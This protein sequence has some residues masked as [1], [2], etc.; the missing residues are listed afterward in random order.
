MTDTIQQPGCLPPGFDRESFLNIKEFCIWQ[1]IHPATF[2][3]WVAR[4][5]VPGYRAANRRIH[6]GTFLDNQPSPRALKHSAGGRHPLP[7]A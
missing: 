7:V 1:R 3:Q 2:S 4:G 5:K 6:V